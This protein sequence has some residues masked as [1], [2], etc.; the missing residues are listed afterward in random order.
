MRA[1][2]AAARVFWRRAIGIELHELRHKVIAVANLCPIDIADMPPDW[3]GCCLASGF[4]GYSSVGDTGSAV[5]RGQADRDRFVAFELLLGVR[6]HPNIVEAGR[7]VLQRQRLRTYTHT[8]THNIYIYA[9]SHTHTHAHTHTH[10]YMYDIHIYM[11]I[12]VIYIYM[13]YI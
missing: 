12:Y 1:V 7:H 11:D 3:A 4:D 5:T 13:I 9:R 2:D 8:H 10:V 6:M